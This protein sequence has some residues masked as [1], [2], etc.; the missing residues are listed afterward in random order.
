MSDSV[1][2]GPLEMRLM[3]FTPVPDWVSRSVSEKRRFLS[4]GRG[5]GAANLRRG[6]GLLW[7][8]ILLAR[9]E[10]EVGFGVW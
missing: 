1:H 9:I 2:S 4:T 3:Y 7:E 8:A 5:L 10:G 6:L